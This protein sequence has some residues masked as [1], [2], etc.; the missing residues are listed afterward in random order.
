MAQ[1]GGDLL[2][3]I[4][5]GR[6]LKKVEDAKESTKQTSQGTDVAAILMRRMA[7]EMSDSEADSDSEED[8][9]DASDSD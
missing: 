7:I 9:S 2:D 6:E 1:Q 8:W 3:A 4:R 5:R